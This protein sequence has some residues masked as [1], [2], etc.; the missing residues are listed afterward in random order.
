MPAAE[1]LGEIAKATHSA[2]M[3][4]RVV[5]PYVIVSGHWT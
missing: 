2:R 4:P 1:F 3:I 5:V